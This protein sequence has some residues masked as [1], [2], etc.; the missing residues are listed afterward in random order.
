VDLAYH[1]AAYLGAS[2]TG[3]PRQAQRTPGQRG[4][5]PRIFPAWTP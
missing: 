3:H 1:L 2:V 5:T 4:C